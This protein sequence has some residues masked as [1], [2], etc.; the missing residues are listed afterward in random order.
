[1]SWSWFKWLVVLRWLIRYALTWEVVPTTQF[2]IRAAVV[3]CQPLTAYYPSE[4]TNHLQCISFTI[5]ST[6]SMHFWQKKGPSPK[7]KHTQNRRSQGARKLAFHLWTSRAAVCPAH[8][9]F[10]AALTS[11]FMVGHVIG[12]CSPFLQLPGESFLVSRVSC[13][14]DEASTPLYKYRKFCF[15][16]CWLLFTFF[17]YVNVLCKM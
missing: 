15:V 14:L 6:A 12:L 10:S 8:I 7:N 9:I 11:I 3:W 5:G 16:V 17:L 4:I 1:M 2:H 13:L